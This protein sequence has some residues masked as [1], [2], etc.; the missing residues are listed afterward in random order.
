MKKHLLFVVFI[1]SF[2]FSFATPNKDSINLKI[3]EN[4]LEQLENQLKEVR[5]DELNYQIERDLLKETYGNNYGSISLIITIVLGIIGLLGFLGIRDIGTIKKEFEIELRDLK[6]IKGQFSTKVTELDSNKKKIDDDLK[7]IIKENE[8][9]SKKIKF[10]ELKERC[11]TFLSENKLLQALEFA[12]AALAITPDDAAVLNIKGR[13]LCRQ[14]QISPALQAYEKALEAD[15]KDSATLLN[16]AECYYFAKEIDKAK[17]IIKENRSLFENKEN[18][19]LL[20]LFDIFDI[21]YSND[22]E[23][24]LTKVKSLIDIKD[25]KSFK[26]LMDGW[27]LQEALYFVAYQP[28]SGIKEILRNLLWYL[29]GQLTGE[30]ICQVLNIEITKQA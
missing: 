26:K 2:F 8:E 18:G 3:L 25:L 6:E 22:N 28:D 17:K 23:R 30:T 14:N 20:L 24:L 12:N 16:S 11:T 10:I 21:Y 27:D 7:Q 15:P 4:K 1:L 5:R 29:D 19:N 13:I 9:Q